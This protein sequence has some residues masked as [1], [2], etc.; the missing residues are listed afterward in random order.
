MQHHKLYRTATRRMTKVIESEI[1]EAIREK[2]NAC[3]EVL[4][5]VQRYQWRKNYELMVPVLL[6]G[7]GKSFGELG[8]QKDKNQKITRD[9]TRIATVLCR[10]NCKFAVMSKADYQS[11]L[12]NLELRRIERLKEFFRQIPFLKLLPRSALNVLHLSLRKRTY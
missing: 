7:P 6:L 11:V 12:G 2:S 4:Q 9:K 3:L 8:V 1:P 10:T 5:C